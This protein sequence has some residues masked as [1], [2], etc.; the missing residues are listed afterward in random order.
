MPDREFVDGQNSFATVALD[1]A[2]VNALLPGPGK[3]IAIVIKFNIAWARKALA[4]VKITVEDLS[5]QCTLPHRFDA[6]TMSLFVDGVR[7]GAKV[8]TGLEQHFHDSCMV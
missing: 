7:V 8:E 6:K 5:D 1:V 2:D 3:E 4:A